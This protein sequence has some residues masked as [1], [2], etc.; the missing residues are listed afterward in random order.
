MERFI[1]KKGMV[2]D[3]YWVCTDQ[4]TGIICTF[5]QGKFN[6]TRIFS[7]SHGFERPDA[8]TVDDAVEKMEIWLGE[9]HIDKII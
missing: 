2:G 7:L 3:N 1:L 8:H 9:N 6:D 4:V 5:E